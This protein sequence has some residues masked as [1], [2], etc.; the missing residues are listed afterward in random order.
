MTFGIPYHIQEKMGL[1]EIPSLSLGGE[2]GAGGGDGAG[3]GA[4]E[5]Q[6]AKTLFNLTL[7]GFGDKAKI[8]V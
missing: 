7:T 6:G 4:E 1:D 3:A 8:K 5:E 2:G